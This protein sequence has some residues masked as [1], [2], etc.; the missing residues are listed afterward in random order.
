MNSPDQMLVSDHSGRKQVVADLALKGGRRLFA[1]PRSTSNLVR[2]DAEK[3]VAYS[4]TFFD[5]RRYTDA[6][7]LSVLLEER[8]RE[9]HE[10]R[11]A[12]VFSCGFWGLVLSM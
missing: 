1:R 4:R 5:A 9:F 7:P 10:C 8:L 6:G 11:E 12:V 2:P 3:L